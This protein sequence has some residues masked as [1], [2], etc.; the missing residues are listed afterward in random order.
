MI[1]PEKAELVGFL[2]AE[3]CYYRYTT[4][5][6]EFDKRRN[7]RYFRTKNEETLQMG[8]NN[9]KLQERFLFLLE[10]VYGYKIRFYGNPH[11]MRCTIKRK[12]VIHDLM[13][14]SKTY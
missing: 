11:S 4:Q 14:Y 9:V 13:K 12:D 10:S 2:C 8:N 6:W 1:T 5:Y 3:G 7:N